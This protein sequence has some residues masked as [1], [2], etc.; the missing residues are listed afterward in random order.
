MPDKRL[1]IPLDEFFEVLTRHRFYLGV[2][3]HLRIRLFLDRFSQ[4]PDA[5]LDTLRYQLAALFSHSAEEQALFYQI[6]DDFT[7]PFF[8]N[9][10]EGQGG[11]PL[12]APKEKP[13]APPPPPSPTLSVAP[14]QPANTPDS[15]V[16]TTTTA[17]R[18]GPIRLELS[19]PANP[20]RIWN[21]AEMDLAIRPLLEKEWAPAQEWDI[22]ASILRTIRAGGIPT[23][24]RRRRKRPPQYLFLIDQKSPRDHLA[25]FYAEL[26]LEFNRRDI[27]AEYFFYD[28]I[29]DRCWKDRRDPGT[30]TTI[31]N[32][33]SEYAGYKLLLI[34]GPE[35]LLER[36]DLRPSN[37]ALDLRENWAQVA[38]LCSKPTADWGNAELA[39]CQLFPVVP[40]NAAGLQT[41]LPQ[42]GATEVFSPQF[43][44][45]ASPE[46]EVP[47]IRLQRPQ[48]VD[49]IIADL[50]HYLGRNGFQW[51]CAA[52]VYP[53]IYWELTALLH[54]ESIPPDAAMNE[55]D[56]NRVWW[57]AL[58]RLSRLGW[59]RQGNIPAPVRERLRRLFDARL[60]LAQRQAVRAQLLQVLEDNPLRDKDSY[61]AA[62]RAFT[63][64]WLDYEQQVVQPDLSP[65]E[66]AKLDTEFRE[67]TAA[68]VALSDIEDAVG[69][70]LFR[71]MQTPAEDT[72][73]QLLWVDDFPENNRGISKALTER[74]IR[75]IEAL[76]TQEALDQLAR[77]SFQ[78]IIS[79][80]GRGDS[81]EAGL[82]MLLVF[83]KQGITVPTGFFAMRSPEYREKM[84]AVGAAM[85]TN[86]ND[87]IVNWVLGMYEQWEA[88]Q[89]GTVP[90][91]LS[92]GLQVLWVDD[93]PQNNTRFQEELNELLHAIFTNAVGTAA[94]LEFLAR[95][96]FDVVVS[97][98]SRHGNNA[99]GADMLRAFRKQNV[100]TP[101]IFYTTPHMVEKYAGELREL[102]AAGVFD[103]KQEIRSFLGRILQAKHAP[104][105]V[106]TTEPPPANNDY[107]QSQQS[108]FE[109]P[110]DRRSDD[111]RRALDSG[112]KATEIGDYAGANT[113]YQ[114]ALAWYTEL[115]EDA[116]RA[117]AQQGL[118]KVAVATNDLE[119]ALRYFQSAATLYL[120]LDFQPAYAYALMDIGSVQ[121]KLERWEAARK[122][123][124]EA[125]GILEEL[126]D[127][128]N[129]KDVRQILLE[130]SSQLSK[131]SPD[132]RARRT[133]NIAESEI[134]L[135]EGRMLY[136]IPYSMQVGEKIRCTVR[137]ASNEEILKRDWKPSE[138]DVLNTI[139]VTDRMYMKLEQKATKESE[140]AFDIKLSTKPDEWLNNSNYSQWLFDVIPSQA[141]TYQLTLKITFFQ[142]RRGSE[143]QRT[144]VVERT[145]NVINRPAKESKIPNQPNSKRKK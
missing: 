103:S 130:I 132:Q 56:M 25:G 17:G 65:E 29:P 105:S 135:E 141:G 12:V 45:S 37:L 50:Q 59:F 9:S 81:R 61:A 8:E 19:F 63:V 39:L 15:P 83:R 3:T 95:S 99:A 143:L 71:E 76:S 28:T 117:N 91:V 92:P 122:S 69:R 128:E 120:T 11:T 24:E 80:L 57:V 36:P 2:D 124:E 70:K 114:R 110:P 52:A 134:H 109:P 73:F 18:S 104:G 26:A 126:G 142:M 86:N 138:F 53:E 34:G 84:L 90:E 123:Y 7:R 108:S 139:L 10:N 93:D 13:I 54:D 85:A 97:D 75:I 67:Q 23:F 136:S 14:T 82:E 140:S 48:D 68:T 22:A 40:A 87:E 121:M 144:E 6:F 100:T 113:N 115:K 72:G 64:A 60:P 127:E 58:L 62:S 33:Q 47:E 118:G 35:G 129:S 46:S 131:E 74:G 101:V 44:K 89:S 112:G 51:L 49:A 42:W 27:T 32:L 78:V 66:R 4:K 41:L 38:L 21:T 137:V 96:R 5:S 106:P 30:F 94:G 125:L 133:R 55:R 98:I 77:H 31:E 1:H 119:A 107:S 16:K 20:L 145:V 111:A 116:G 43:W 88:D 79:D 102:G